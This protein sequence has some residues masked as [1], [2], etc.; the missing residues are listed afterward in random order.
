MSQYAKAGLPEAE[1]IRPP[2]WPKILLAEDYNIETH[3]VKLWVPGKSDS[4]GI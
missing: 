1:A 3:E 4:Y 2:A